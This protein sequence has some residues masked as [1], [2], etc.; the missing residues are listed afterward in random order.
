MK[1]ASESAV[2]GTV[3]TFFPQ[4]FYRF[5]PQCGGGIPQMVDSLDMDEVALPA[6]SVGR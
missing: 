3:G 4:L 5:T 6:Q 1:V 2:T